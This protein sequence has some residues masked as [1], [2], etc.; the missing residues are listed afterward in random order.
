MRELLAEAMKTAMRSKDAIGLS[1]LR[2][3]NAAVHDRDIANRGASKGPITDE[4]IV[5]VLGKMVKQREESAR[6]YDEAGRGEL[7]E[8][9]RQE[10]G[11]IRQFLPAQLGEE[12]VR[13]AC[14][15]VVEEIGAE[16]L[17]DIGRC[18]SALKAKYP[19]KMDFSKANGIV[20][21]LLQ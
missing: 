15:Q 5:G 19:G 10:I 2:L 21:E 6:I 9:E 16:G 7:A 13:D 4:E 17:R 20:K 14:R 12:A 18:M 8:R 11:V 1:T 3:I